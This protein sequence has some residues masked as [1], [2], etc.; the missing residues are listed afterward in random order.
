MDESTKEK[1]EAEGWKFGDAAD[2]L[3]MTPEEKEY[4][5]RRCA[6]LEDVMSGDYANHLWEAIEKTGKKKGKK[7]RRKII[8]DALIELG[9]HCQE[10]EWRLNKALKR[11]ETLETSDARQ[12]D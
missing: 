3:E 1:L 4:L 2:F 11:I 12:A 8:Y 10:L 9:C 6:G 5:D 7:K